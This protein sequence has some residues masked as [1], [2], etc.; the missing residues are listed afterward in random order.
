V[1]DE[2]RDVRVPASGRAGLIARLARERT[3]AD[4]ELV[5]LLAPGWS[6][7]DEQALFSAAR[8]AR[9]RTYGHVVYLRG[10]I[11]FTS[12]CR[13]DCY[14]C[15]LRAGN[16]HA[17]RY[18]LDADTI[19]ACCEQG[20]DLGLRTFVLQ[21]GDDP[22]FSDDRVCAIVAAIK[23]RFADCAV[24]LSIGE[25]EHASYQAYFDAGADRY[26]LREET[27]DPVHYRRLHPPELSCEHR[28]RCLVDLKAIGYQVGCGLMVGS[29]G[30]TVADVIADLRFM[31]RL[32]PHMIGIGPF[33]PHHDTPFA[34]EPAG[35]MADTL[36]LLG[37]LRLMFPHALLPATTA[38]GTVAADGRRLGLLA[39][40]NVIMPNLSP[41]GV[42]GK[43]LLYD[44][45]LCSGA[46][47][48]ENH[49]ALERVVGSAG[50]EV[51]VSR[52]DYVG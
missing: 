9:E 29:P 46:E 42:R 19:L 11:E 15:G 23:A 5:R 20:Y 35:S 16:A 44:G 38:L 3:L 2:E 21:G 26:L 24:T 48:A 47:A 50:C 40:A 43:Y 51:V 28:K 34:H 25:R 22:F 8:E 13:N 52:G 14:Y 31:E 12:H 36:H 39:G 1:T 6:E 10:L 4:A 32:G 41:A 30:Q 27:A 49:A 45:K 18:R 33:L 37:I 7:A 17:E